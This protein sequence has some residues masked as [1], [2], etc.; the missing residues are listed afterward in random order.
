MAQSDEK[1]VHVGFKIGLSVPNLV[2]SSDEE[3]TR[4]Y[5]SRFTYNVGGLV[6]VDVN[7]KFSIQTEV[8]YAPQGGKRNGIQ[9]ITGA[10]PG[11][12]P[13]PAGSYYF[14]DFKNTA[15][16]DYVE[17][18]VL[19][20]Y[21]FGKRSGTRF[22]VNAG[23][24]TGFLVKATQETRG[25]STIYLDRNGTPL[26]L[27]PVGTP[28]PPISFDA[29]TDVTKNLNRVNFGITGGGGLK[30]A[31]KDNYYFVDVRGSYG[32]NRLQKN[33]ATDGTSRTGNFIVSF[34]YAFNV[35]GK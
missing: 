32:F 33:P 1:Q 21:N 10:L 3:I 4:D 28:I 14:G 26:L 15:K 2:G 16:L 11:L 12:P 31:H 18:P 29:D 25:S 8:N 17:V 34:G 7:K 5:K 19:F 20:R 6:E 24:N 23:P 13:M 9:P 27:P 35:W 30:F 22:Y